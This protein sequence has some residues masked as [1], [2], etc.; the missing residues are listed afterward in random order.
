[1]MKG[2]FFLA[3]TEDGQPF[4]GYEYEDAASRVTLFLANKS[5]AQAA[6]LTF[7]R[8]VD[9]LMKMDNKLVAVEGSLDGLRKPEGRQQHKPRGK[10]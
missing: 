1:M 4:L 2:G 5:T 3:Y 8:A 7:N 9:E 6:K 10:G